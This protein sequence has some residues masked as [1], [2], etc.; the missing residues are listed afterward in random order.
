MKKTGSK[1]SRD[2][3]PLKEHFTVLIFWP[4]SRKNAFCVVGEDSE[5]CLAH[6]PMALNELNLP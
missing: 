5:P 4:I 6:S 3:V 2:T 1:K